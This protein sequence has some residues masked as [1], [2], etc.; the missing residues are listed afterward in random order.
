MSDIGIT[1][2]NLTSVHI[3]VI[4]IEATRDDDPATVMMCWIARRA[5]V[6]AGTEDRPIRLAREY[7]AEV[8]RERLAEL[9]G[10]RP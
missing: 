2:E 7:V 10:K 8:L 6:G 1:H 4:E 9:A 3:T 5:C